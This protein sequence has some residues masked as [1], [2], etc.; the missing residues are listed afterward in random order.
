M[1]PGAEINI[2]KLEP[3]AKFTKH[4]ETCTEFGI[5]TPT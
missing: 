3:F 5:E 4:A 2:R 1:H